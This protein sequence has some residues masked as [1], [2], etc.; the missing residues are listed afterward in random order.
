MGTQN[1]QLKSI[2]EFLAGYNPIY[3]PILPGFLTGGKST[4][5]P[6]EAG[7]TNFKRIEA[8]GDL[9]GNRISPKDTSIKRA[10]AILASKTFKQY[11]YANQFVNSTLQRADQVD[12]AMAQIL[13][14]HFK[15]A[16]EIMVTGDGTTD[17]DVLNNGLLFSLDSNYTKNVSSEVPTSERLAAFHALVMSVAL[18]ANKVSGAKSIM[19]Y[20]SNILPLY[21][22]IHSGSGRAVNAA[23]QEALDALG[24]FSQMVLPSEITPS[25]QNGFLIVNRDQIH[26]HTVPLPQILSRGVDER[27]MEVWGNFLTGSNMIEVLAK[28]GIIRQPLTLAA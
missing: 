4:I 17:S 6:A 1:I 23:L 26:T 27:S 10:A 5:M 15:H 8:S 11:F 2:D 18:D 24:D 7:I 25:G 14:A 3:S 20:G 22:G 9:R 19:Y 13:D 12:D 28:G 16:D 21:T